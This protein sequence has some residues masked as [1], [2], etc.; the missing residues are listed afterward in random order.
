[1]KK[2]FTTR[3]DGRATSGSC[4]AYSFGAKPG[5]TTVYYFSYGK[6]RSPKTTVRVRPR[7]TIAADDVA[8]SAG[9]TITFMG[10][11]RPLAKAGATVDLRRNVGGSWIAVAEGTV[12]ADGSYQIPWTGE[13]GT[14]SFKVRV[15]AGDQLLANSSPVV[16][17]GVE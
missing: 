17:V 13:R 3:V 10:T 15:A 12:A 4:T 9:D 1:M 6:S 8:V 7:I 16:S 11:V 14:W 5:R 2:S